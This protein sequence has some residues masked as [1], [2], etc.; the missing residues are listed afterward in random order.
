MRVSGASGI[1][2][3][4]MQSDGLNDPGGRIWAEW[5]GPVRGICG[6]D[7][8]RRGLGRR[9]LPTVPRRDPCV[10]GQKELA[11]EMADELPDELSGD[12]LM[13]V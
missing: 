5:A 7:P 13:T 11:D 6:W 3:G 10:G 9:D 8:C 12:N 1:R 2:V 4:G